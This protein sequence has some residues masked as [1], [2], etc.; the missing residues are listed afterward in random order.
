MYRLLF[1]IVFVPLSWLP[2]RVLYVISDVMCFFLRDVFKYRKDII[3]NNIRNSF[4]EKDE[5]EI[6]QIVK[7]FYQHL[8]DIFIEAFK[9]LSLSR[10]AVMKRYCCKNPELINAYFDQGKSVVMMSGHFNNWEYMVLSLDMQFKHHGIGVGKPLSNKGFGKILTDFRTRYGTEVID[11]TNSRE[12]FAKY[13]ADKYLCNYMMLNDQ[14]P[15]DTYK[16]YWANFLDQDTAIIYGPEHYA[17][18]YDYPVFFYSVNKIKRGYY[19]FEV[20]LITD[21][22]NETTY[23]EITEKGAHLLEDAIRKNPSQWLWSHKRWKQQRPADYKYR[24]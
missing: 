12:K 7:Q 24:N 13:D 8:S 23:G 5:I 2:M 10:K 11:A 3:T 18:K 15:G 6:K 14:W 21:K 4:K 22:P 20:Q 19:E 17:K 1:Y 16:C 9:M